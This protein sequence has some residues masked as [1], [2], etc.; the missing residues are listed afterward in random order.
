M[1]LDVLVAVKKAATACYLFISRQPTNERLAYHRRSPHAYL[2]AAAGCGENRTGLVE[3]RIETG[4]QLNGDLNGDDDGPAQASLPPHANEVLGGGGS[5]RVQ[6]ESTIADAST[7]PLLL[8]RDSLGPATVVTGGAREPQSTERL[9]PRAGKGED[10]LTA[11][12]DVCSPE[13]SPSERGASADGGD[14][15]RGLRAAGVSTVGAVVMLSIAVALAS[16]E[17]RRTDVREEGGRGQEIAGGRGGGAVEGGGDIGRLAG[18]WSG[19]TALLLLLS[20]S[21]AVAA[22]STVAAG[23]LWCA[24]RVARWREEIFAGSPVV[25]EVFSRVAAL[26]RNGS[27]EE[28]SSPSAEPWGSAEG[29]G[30]GGG[31]SGRRRPVTGNCGANDVDDDPVGNIFRPGTRASQEF[32]T[33][34]LISETASTGGGWSS[35]TA[36]PKTAAAVAAAATTAEDAGGAVVFL[37][38]VTGLVGQMVLFDLLRQGA[39]AARVTSADDDDDA[40]REECREV[41]S[42][43]RGLRRVVVLVRS[44]KGVCASDRLA[45]I[46][47]SPMFRPLRESGTWVDGGEA[48]TAGGAEEPPGAPSPSCCSP[49]NTSG[50]GLRWESKRG[51]GTVVTAVEGEL[52]KEGLGLAAEARALLAGAGVTHA[53]HC[54]ASVSFSD[55]LAEAAATNVTGA[56]RVAALVASW[57]SCG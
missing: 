50:L 44:K 24:I 15:F 32:Y 28:H 56:L 34:R 43:S 46:R 12:V 11:Q 25:T 8:S 36:A 51:G 30:G 42:A 18:A 2:A 54:A 35:T 41:G 57:P 49:T 22:V 38:G 9:G 6:R 1:V 33:P 29:S 20:V 17:Y 27:K 55:P 40:T 31:S 48:G 7:V 5:E 45:S 47:D 4:G 53:L 13:P 23:C 21:A 10:R 39:A 14:G 3:A 19:A 16:G 26:D 37:T 52:G